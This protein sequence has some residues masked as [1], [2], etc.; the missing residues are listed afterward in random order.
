MTNLN[1]QILEGLREARQRKGYSQRA[2]R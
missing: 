1:D 2:K